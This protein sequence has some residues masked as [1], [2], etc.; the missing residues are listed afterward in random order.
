MQRRIMLLIG[1]VGHVVLGNFCMMQIAM[2]AD[3]PMQHEAMEMVMTPMEPMTPAHCKQC[4]HFEKQ[5]PPMSGGCAGHCLFQSHE[6]APVMVQ[7]VGQM[8]LVAALPPSLTS[9]THATTGESFVESTAPPPE[10]NPTRTIV[11]LE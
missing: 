11:L 10:V 4:A 8:F 1:F 5:Q 2:A 3:M 9:T 6:V 7:N